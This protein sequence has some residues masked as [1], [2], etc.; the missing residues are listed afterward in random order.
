MSGDTEGSFGNA[1]AGIAV[2]SAAWLGATA[3]LVAKRKQVGRPGLVARRV[4]PQH[5]VFLPRAR[6]R[7]PSLPVLARAR[8]FGK[9]GAL[10]TGVNF[11][12]CAQRYEWYHKRLKNV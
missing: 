7:L 5:V 8:L 6:A 3:A 10:K 4:P 11:A 12:A 1:Q 9:S 2:I